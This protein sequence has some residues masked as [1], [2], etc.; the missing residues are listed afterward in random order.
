M[1]A[2]SYL[3]VP[4]PFSSALSTPPPRLYP[5]AWSSATNCST[6]NFFLPFFLLFGLFRGKARA[7]AIDHYYTESRGNY[8]AVVLAAESSH[9]T[10]RANRGAASA[11]RP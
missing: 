5:L 7:K 3:A 8:Q 10:W 4:P 6:A 9:A 11:P 1:T 2:S